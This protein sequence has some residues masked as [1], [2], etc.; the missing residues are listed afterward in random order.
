MKARVGELELEYEIFGESSNPA[1]LLI[2]GLGA[3]MIAWP[4]LFCRKLAERGLLVVRFDHL[5]FLISR[6]VQLFF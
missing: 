5:A 4:E 2:M 1:V 6:A 3:Q